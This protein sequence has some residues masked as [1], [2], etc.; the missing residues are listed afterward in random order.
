MSQFK[1]FILK[2]KFFNSVNGVS[3][4]VFAY[5]VPALAQLQF[6]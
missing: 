4:H 1:A 2:F 5:V 3:V 6:I